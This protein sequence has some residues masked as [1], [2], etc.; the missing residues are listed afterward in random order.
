MAEYLAPGV[1][2]EE[3]DSGAKP[4]E[5]VSTSTA[6]FVG[7]TERGPVNVPMLVTSSGD[8]Q[9]LFGGMI[10]ADEFTGSA[11]GVHAFLPHAIDGF[12]T[13]GGK[14]A[15]VVRSLPDEASRAS[16]EMFTAPLNAATPM[17]STLL[18]R[19]AG[20]GTG[21]T[22][23]LMVLD[24][25]GFAVNDQLR[26]GTGSS[27]EYAT[28]ALITAGV[29]SEIAIAEPL[30]F[31]HTAG[32]AV[33]EHAVAGVV[34]LAAAITLFGDA[35]GGMRQIVVN[36]T[37]D[38]VGGGAASNLI[39]LSTDGR[40]ELCVIAAVETAGTNRFRLTL[41]RP[42]RFAHDAG[43][44]LTLIATDNTSVRALE[45]DAI[46]GDLAVFTDT[47]GGA[48]VIVELDPGGPA[49]EA[50]RSGQL[51][52]MNL[53]Q[54]IPFAVAPGS[55]VAQ[56]TLVDN[57]AGITDKALN[58]AVTS[59]SRTIALDNREGV[60]A[61]QTLRIGAIG[62]EEYAVI[63][64]VP[65]E[66]AAGA[67]PG[68]VTLSQPLVFN[69]ADGSA[70]VVQ[71]DPAFPGGGHAEGAVYL[72]ATA[73]STAL[74][75]SRPAGWA[76]GQFARIT[77]PSGDSALVGLSAAPVNAAPATLQLTDGLARSHPVGTVAIEREALFEVEALDAGSWGNRLVVS[78]EN[79]PRGLA[80][81]T[82]VAITPPLQ[83]RVASLTG[84]EPG[85]LLELI[86]PDTGASLLVKARRIDRSNGAV[87]LDT[88][89]LTP[90]RLAALGPITDPI[91][92]RSREFRLTVRLRRRPDPAVPSRNTLILASESFANLAMDHRHSR[93]FQR[94]IGDTMGEPRL[95]DGRPDGESAFVRVRDGAQGAAT[96]PL[97]RSGPE[98]LT[99]LLPGAIVAPAHQ[100]LAGGDD[101][102]VS[103]SDAVHIG[104]DAAEPRDR[105]GLAALRNIP[106]VSMVG[107]PGRGSAG[108]HSGLIAHCE[109]M[110]YRIAVLDNAE[111]DD[112]LADV[113]QQRQNFDTKYAAIYY[114]WLT[115]PD[116]MPANLANI[117]QFA[118]PP[119]GH[120]MG[121]FARTD[122]ERGVH[123]APANEVVRGI[124]GLTRTLHKGEHDI[125][126]PSPVNINV[127]RD[128]RPD[129]RGIRVFGARCITSDQAHK[130][131][132][133]RRL[134][135]FLEQSI[136][137][138]LQW[139][140]FEPNAEPL[141]ARVTQTVG[142]FLTD[143][144]RSGALE[145][146]EP[147]QGYFVRCDRTTMTQSD[148][149]NG[150]LICVIGVAPVKPAEFVI[151]RIGLTTRS[152]EAA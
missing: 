49:H 141:W 103:M 45:T 42:L 78:V 136:E 76:A 22:V 46:P 91:V 128:F 13:N 20:E 70:A 40:D 124:G 120:V 25:A 61:G 62:V 68:P 112:G 132:P 39:E 77:T 96:E 1:Y 138:G 38:L 63:V 93:Y 151:I 53:A 148:I 4:I 35:A 31:G 28:I 101:S 29:T 130:Y 94:V 87:T 33:A 131:V 89:G 84:V 58:G 71:D 54:P 129:G 44:V 133:V 37:D 52:T 81:T 111:P 23:P 135:M 149:D 43:D 2:L 152:S 34:G 9:R 121:I 69:H 30:V 126:N 65:G 116:P 12:F 74:L 145:G 106:T 105:T 115:V 47:A 27:A 57:A 17:G 119:S 18:L 139:V 90:A 56:V 60:I 48:G 15:W 102:L 72:A 51:A 114:P 147:G 110:R 104:T 144:W 146:T 140:T 134:L 150:R 26:V 108:I 32:D 92:V 113:M 24:P 98:V 7:M 83:F 3:I 19:A 8:F 79:E 80:A 66:R 137:I 85:S 97:M 117:G 73:G 67:D 142:N 127:I 143:V 21:T 109:A 59:G 41:N 36:T 5:G 55:R 82:I 14:R 118:L 100:R 64:S 123:K 50:V 95:E 6:G 88:P 75:V 125:L 86:N 10:P 99:D 122:E 11:G 107:I 16:T